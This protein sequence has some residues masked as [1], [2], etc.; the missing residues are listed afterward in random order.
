M[1]RMRK[2]L[3]NTIKKGKGCISAE[4]S[5][6]KK[7]VVSDSKQMARIL[8]VNKFSRSGTV[9]RV[10]TILECVLYAT[11]TTAPKCLNQFSSQ[12]STLLSPRSTSTTAACRVSQTRQGPNI[13]IADAEFASLKGQGNRYDFS[14]NITNLMSGETLVNHRLEL[15]MPVDEL[16]KKI[17]ASRNWQARH[18]FIIHHRQ[19]CSMPIITPRELARMLKNGGF[20]PRDFV[21]VWASSNV[22]YHVVEDFLAREELQYNLMPP[23]ENVMRVLHAW[24]ELLPKVPCGL[25]K[26][27]ELVFPNSPLRYVHHIA[28]VDTKKLGLMTWKLRDLNYVTHGPKTQ[29]DLCE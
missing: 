24:R 27:F 9:D 21:F 11:H 13:W 18:Q 29:L 20:G 5:K 16:E 4:L 3:A 23:E 17:C 15:S 14:V 8:H 1:P 28:D 6:D 2:P 10:L 7:I 26:L 22:D 12:R 25:H 19:P